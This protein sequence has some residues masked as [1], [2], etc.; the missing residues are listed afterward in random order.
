[1][2]LIITIKSE[3]RYAKCIN[4]A[5]QANIGLGRLRE[6]EQSKVG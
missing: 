6:A 3:N 1:M 2:T 4:L 5:I